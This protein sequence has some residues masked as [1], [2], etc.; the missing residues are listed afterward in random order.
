M[1]LEAEKFRAADARAL[2]DNKL[3]KEAFSAVESYLEAKALTCDPDN[4]EMAQRVILSKQILA[5]VRREIQRHVE[6]GVVAEI[7]MA[8]LE[9]RKAFS[10]FRR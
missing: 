2:L 7:R 8:E 5:A 4:R 10:I 6:N 1:S 3:F 9:K